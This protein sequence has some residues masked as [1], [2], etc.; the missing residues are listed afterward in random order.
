MAS[1]KRPDPR[2]GVDDPAKEPC[3]PGLDSA[4]K[5]GPVGEHK[6]EK[7]DLEYKDGIW[8]DSPVAESVPKREGI[9]KG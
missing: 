7:S 2:I 9:D 3:P 4:G 8:R 6:Q 5:L 1:I